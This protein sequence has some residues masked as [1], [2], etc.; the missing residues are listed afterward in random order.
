MTLLTASN[1]KH[2]KKDKKTKTKMLEDETAASNKMAGDANKLAFDKTTTKA[3]DDRN[4][5]QPKCGV[6]NVPLPVAP[7]CRTPLLSKL[8]HKRETRR[9]VLVR[10]GGA[11]V[12]T[13]DVDA[14]N[15]VLHITDQDLI[16]PSTSKLAQ[17]TKNI[18]ELAAATPDLSTL[19][20]AF[21]TGQALTGAL[22]GKG[23]F[24]VFAPS[25]EAF[26]KLPKMTLDNLLDPKNITELRAV[27]AYHVHSGVAV[28]DYE[29]D[30]GYHPDGMKHEQE[31][32]MLDG[33]QLKIVNTCGE[34]LIG[35]GGAKVTSAAIEA[36]NGVVHIIHQVLIPPSTPRTSPLLTKDIVVPV[37]RAWPP[38]PTHLAIRPGQTQPDQ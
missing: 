6:L 18:V 17:E 38:V 33:Q 27:L 22:S 23:P 37:R 32:E 35:N 25:N 29:N 2:F 20:I 9:E 21:E 31:V 10:S 14:S 5:R 36:S 26:A 1:R 8:K 15:G 16:P 4:K 19:V 28:L 3:G 30:F 7:V 13:A 11:K 24:T 34:V 12:T